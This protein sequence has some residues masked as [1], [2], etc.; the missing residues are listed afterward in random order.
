M[1]KDR[2]SVR[3]KSSK[4]HTRKS[5]KKDKRRKR[6]RTDSLSISDESISRHR[7][8][9][10]ST[11]VDKSTKSV[12][13][14]VEYSDVSSED[15]SDP[16]AGEI[17]DDSIEKTVPPV[18]KT[19]SKTTTK[20]T[21]DSTSSDDGYSL[22]RKESLEI[23]EKV[24]KMSP[25]QLRRIII[26]SP[27][28]SSSNSSSM[29]KSTTSSDQKRL[30]EMELAAE[31][32]DID[33]YLSTDDN[34]LLDDDDDDSEL[35][36]K[37]KR[38]KSK[39]D[40]KHKKSKK[41]K[42]RKKKRQKSISSIETLSDLE[43]LLERP[44]YTPPPIG[45]K[46]MSMG[47]SGGSPSDR[48]NRGATHNSASTY[49]PMKEVS[50]LSVETPPLRPNSS[51]S[52]YSESASNLPGA[53]GSGGVGSNQHLNVP[54]TLPTATTSIHVTASSHRRTT[55]NPKH[56][57]PPMRQMPGS[58]GKTRYAAS[59]HTPPL[60]NSSKT[61]GDMYG[62]PKVP[63]M[64]HY[65]HHHHRNTGS[66]GSHHHHHH[67]Q[68]AG[69]IESRKINAISPDD[70][71]HHQP[72]TPP[73]KRRKANE[74]RTYEARH[75]VSRQDFHN[76]NRFNKNKYNF[77]KRYASPSSPPY[78]QY[79][80]HSSSSTRSHKHKYTVSS[81]SPVRSRS[82]RRDRYSRSRSPRTSSHQ[83]ESSSPRKRHSRSR[84]YSLS[85]I[86]EMKQ[87]R[88]DY[89][90]KISETSLFAELVKDKHKREKALKEIIEKQ[91]ENSNGGL[92]NVNDSSLSNDSPT[93]VKPSEEAGNNDSSSQQQQQRVA[94]GV[95]LGNNNLD[96]VNIPMPTGN[97]VNLDAIDGSAPPVGFLKH[98]N[99]GDEAPISNNNSHSSSNDN[100]N[101]PNSDRENDVL[102]KTK[103]NSKPKSL[104]AL[105][106]PPGVSVADL[107]N[108]PTPSPPREDLMPSPKSPTPTPTPEKKIIITKTP[109]SVANKSLLNLPMPPMVPGSEDLSGDDE[110]IGSPDDMD[111]VSGARSS[112]NSDS[113]KRK[114]P[115]IL[116]RRD[117]RSNVRDW[118]ER[119]VDV[120]E[121]ISRIGEGTYGEVYKARD[122]HTSELVALKKVRLEH[123]KE[124]FPITAVREI[125]ILRQL[126][127][128]NIVNLHEIVT[129]KQDALEFRKDKG[130]FYL[131]FEYMDHDLM[132][133]LESGMV[134]F[135]EENNA[136]IMK[137]LLDGLNYCH[138]RNFL[139]RDIKCSNILM[140]N[141]GE[142]KLADFGLARL[143]NAE[144]RER[145][146]TNKVIT[147]WYRSPEL[148]LGE[149]RYGP[150]ID[151]WSCG[152]I[153]GELFMKRPLFQASSEMPQLDTIARL[154]GSPTPAVW[155]NVIK[156]PLFH[157][158]KQ[159]KLHRRRLREEFEF[160]PT[161]ALDL[162]DK[163]LE[164]NPDKRITAEDALKSPWLK[165]VFPE[166]M[167]TPELPTW[168]D[169]HELWSKMRRKREKQ[170]QAPVAASGPV[171]RP[172]AAII[173]SN[174]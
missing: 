10:T 96:I 39:K 23:E 70:R 90:K 83:Y 4:N 36:H 119:C 120:F 52:Y 95:K 98:P 32:D 104:T 35:E 21:I 50:P 162:L 106:M 66:M 113:M 11:K 159:K 82:P 122:N 75:H 127:H 40:K 74:G 149:E 135:S 26:G 133:L 7:H 101:K 126:N 12:N 154:C 30:A 67:R 138:K 47:K 76:Y 131:V 29:Q 42:K 38:K 163:M 150:S 166:Q 173:D 165:N 151:V 6:S 18:T 65:H 45:K 102:N 174:A 58:S 161:P 144:D 112:N 158:I 121:I 136:S 142:V 155:P 69:Q 92:I 80:R 27:I 169:C 85:P 137:Q 128:R 41:S 100:N 33:E 73:H 44:N 110:I 114:R 59:P 109:A 57:T 145:P 147:L 49:T 152:C 108:A 117:S 37:R 87:K 64:E 34:S 84:S 1:D 9:S 171:V 14:L 55:P 5:S 54:N 123:E 141:K 153:L 143:Y 13:A 116:N 99:I 68:P 8:R 22:K 19:D 15:F 63:P 31:E 53:S 115:V 48:W 168:Q 56:R 88:L 77:N 140:N 16:E 172:S 124:G 97:T 79:S 20:G 62:S 93:L 61:K 60:Y 129:D 24:A 17:N 91:E 105:P 71:Y 160:M 170:E 25:S 81:P 94:N 89:S 164:L 139:H 111:L 51:N 130:S 134:A 146:Y 2:Q 118:G 167:P 46:S 28:N 132:G 43:E 156:L 125:K 3:H 86:D 78:A 103:V 148:L 107:V 72:A 157:A